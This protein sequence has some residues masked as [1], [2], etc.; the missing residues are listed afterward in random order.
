MISDFESVRV[1]HNLF[2]VKTAIDDIPAVP[3][4]DTFNLRWKLIEEEF[5][6]LKEEFSALSEYFHPNCEAYEDEEHAKL[7]FAK[8]GKEMADLIYVLHGAGLAFGLNMDDVF[9]EVHRS[10]MSKMPPDGIILRR[11]DGKVIK[12]PTY[13]PADVYQVLYGASQ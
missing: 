3:D 13:S 1:F 12:P 5:D 2:D 8:I 7:V 4:E 10:N 9:T 6:E 11:D